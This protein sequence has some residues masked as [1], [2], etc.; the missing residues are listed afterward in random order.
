MNV[1]TVLF[2]GPQGSGK[3]TQAKLLAEFLEREDGHNVLHLETGAAFRDLAE[4]DTSTGQRVRS[5]MQEGEVQPA[6]LAIRLWADGFINELTEKTHLVLDG[7]PRTRLEA[8]ALDESLG[9]YNRLPSIVIYLT[10]SEDVI[11]ERLSD[12]ARD[13]DYRRAIETRLAEYEKKTVPIISFYESSD[14][15]KLFEVDGEQTIEAIQEQIQEI[16]VND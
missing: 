7:S 9:F 15:Y 14:N 8:E 5:S 13:D 3:G 12:R 6:F 2:V 16:L 1:K 11:F 4:T 10:L